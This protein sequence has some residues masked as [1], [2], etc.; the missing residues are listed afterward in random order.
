MRWEWT[1]AEASG[2]TVREIL[3]QRYGC[4]RR[5]L[6]RLKQQADSVCINGQPVW[7]NAVPAP[8]D[9]VTV[10]LEEHLEHIPSQV[11][12]L[13]IV[14]EDEHIIVINKVAG[15]VVH[16]TRGY[17]EGTLANALA[18]HTALPARLVTRLDKETSGLVLAAKSAWAHHRLNHSPLK[19]EYLGIARGIPR[20]REG[21]INLSIGW[22]SLVPTRRGADPRGKPAC[23]RYQTEVA[24]AGLALVKLWPQTGRTHQLRIHMANIGCPLADD[25]IYG[26]VE[27]I[28]GRTALHATAIEFSHPA[29]GKTMRMT[30]PLPE[31]MARIVEG[32]KR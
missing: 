32:M 19:R 31:D 21:E 3:R 14:Y 5:Q 2:N 15:M 27:G 11:I 22:D 7:L 6:I 9:R 17:K 12:P 4:S 13:D 26:R 8:G 30:A 23:T 1:V 24:V 25:Y 16:P 18:A 10:M 29:T 28:V 20:P